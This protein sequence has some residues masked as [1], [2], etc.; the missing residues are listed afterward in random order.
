MIIFYRSTN[1]RQTNVLTLI[2]GT[3]VHL[4]TMLIPCGCI[5]LIKFLL[6]YFWTLRRRLVIGASY[7]ALE[8]AGFLTAFGYDTTDLIRSIPLRGFDQQMA[9]KI[10]RMLHSSIPSH[11][12]TY[13]LTYNIHTDIT[14]SLHTSL[15]TSLPT[16]M[17]A[18]IYIN[19][20]HLYT[21]HYY[22]YTTILLYIL[23]L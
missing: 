23:L 11:S 14:T 10:G 1:T 20:I 22:Y 16:Y 3:H 12:R 21:L 9:A 7:V 8:C 15:P 5:H 18:C 6:A 19:I 4:Y 2:I 17:C 13:L